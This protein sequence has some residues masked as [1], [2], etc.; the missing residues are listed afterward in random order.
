MHWGYYMTSWM[1]KLAYHYEETRNKYPN[2]ELMIVF[3]IDNTIIDMREMIVYVLTAYDRANGTHYFDKLSVGNLTINENQV[4]E[5]LA[6]LCI[7]EEE[8]APILEWYVAQRWT[9]AAILSSRRPYAGVMEVIR[10]FQMQ[11]QT[12]VS[13]NTGRPEVIREDTL[14]SLNALGSAYKVE[15]RDDLLHMNPGSWEDE[16]TGSKADGIRKFQRAGYRV[17]AVVD[18]E[19]DNLEAIAAIDD[20]QAM[21]MLHAD[22]IFDSCRS[23]LPDTSVSGSD[24]D[25]TEL[26]QRSSLPEHIRFVWHGINDEANLRQFLASEVQW[27]ECDAR[28][29]SMSNEVVLRHDGFSDRL[30]R[31]G[32]EM[33]RFEDVVLGLIAAGK[34][35]KIDIKER[36]PL[37]DEVVRILTLHE[38]RDEDLWI[39]GNAV[40]LGEAFFQRVAKR[41]P[42]ATIQCGVG[43]LSPLMLD[44]PSLIHP[45][46]EAL[47]SA[48]VNRF[49]LS[50]KTPQLPS[51]IDQLDAWEYE[52]NI[53]NVPD[54]E[55]FLRAILLRPM[56][57]TS[58]FNF[59]K[60]HLYG[61]G[62]GK[63]S[64]HHTYALAGRE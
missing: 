56:S 46:L 17:F 1:K 36:G 26:I 13:L 59:P 58:D 16:V 53:Y 33:L 11:P 28:W 64:R 63:D 21:L 47:R 35:I 60:W 24:Y 51:L 29:D 44:A 39:N 57:V 19:P 14:R 25:L 30:R 6:E 48:G 32:E 5:L 52:T 20:E 18:N 8:Q 42:G 12:H 37:F 15:F 22:T 7:D 9:S 49:S 31:D 45:K 55:S 23:K 4:P 38:V 62:A 54:L 3:D 10:W 27:G 61:R 40:E 43:H 34:S 2:D 50:W 41:F